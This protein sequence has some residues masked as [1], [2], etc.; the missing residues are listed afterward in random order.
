[1]KLIDL[2]SRPRKR[3]RHPDEIAPHVADHRTDRSSMAELVRLLREHDD[4][5]DLSGASER[6]DRPG[7]PTQRLRSYDQDR[8]HG[9][10]ERGA[11][12]I[13]GRRR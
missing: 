1:M 13:A 2:F 11:G 4:A 12:T 7:S 9:E 3:A 5:R 6:S 10:G 8:H